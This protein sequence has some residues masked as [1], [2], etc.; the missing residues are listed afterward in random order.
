MTMEYAVN[1]PR[2]TSVLAQAWAARRPGVSGST[3]NQRL[4]DARRRVRLEGLLA[5]Q[6]A[7]RQVQRARRN[8]TAARGALETA[9]RRRRLAQL[10]VDVEFIGGPR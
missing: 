9:A 2:P 6:H 1:A 8:L 7:D 3:K 5:E 4:E 10:E